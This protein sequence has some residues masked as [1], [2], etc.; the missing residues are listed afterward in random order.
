ME[1]GSDHALWQRMDAAKEKDSPLFVVLFCTSLLGVCVCCPF[2]SPL[3]VLLSLSVCAHDI[4]MCFTLLYGFRVYLSRM[5]VSLFST[6]L[7]FP[8]SPL[9]SLPL[10][11]SLSLCRPH[12]PLPLHHFA[13]APFAWLCLSMRF[14][15]TMVDYDAAG[16]MRGRVSLTF[17]LVMSLSC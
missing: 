16:S 17:S 10:P 4:T 12:P 3:F 8:V 2:L 11:L 14:F 7:S 1:W 15:A 9:P 13:F 6:R 5:C